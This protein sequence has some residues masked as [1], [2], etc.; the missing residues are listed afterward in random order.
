[1]CGVLAPRAPP[2]LP[3]PSPTWRLKRRRYPR[4]CGHVVS[5]GV[6]AW[7]AVS[8]SS[9]SRGLGRVSRAP[10]AGRTVCVAQLSVRAHWTTPGGRQATIIF[11]VPELGSWG[12]R[13]WAGCILVAMAGFGDSSLLADMLSARVRGGISSVGIR[14]RG[15]S[16]AVPG[17]PRAWQGGRRVAGSRVGPKGSPEGPSTPR[18]GRSWRL[19]DEE[20]APGG[21][22]ANGA[23][24]VGR[25]LLAGVASFPALPPW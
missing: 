8:P 4:G 2:P 12:G 14:S 11:I 18:G 9:G 22:V 17:G 13:F 5:I 3:Q 23:S 1:M 10:L 7:V 21:R 19:R 25:G 15:G 24:S 6:A 16:C 20:G